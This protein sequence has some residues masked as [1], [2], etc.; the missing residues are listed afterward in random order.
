VRLTRDPRGR[1]KSNKNKM[2][3]LGNWQLKHA[4]EPLQHA[5][6]LRVLDA[7]NMGS[8]RG[9]DREG[10][11]HLRE[12]STNG[13]SQSMVILGRKRAARWRANI[14]YQA[15]AGASEHQMMQGLLTSAVSIASTKMRLSRC[16]K[17]EEQS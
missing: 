12:Q 2:S 17:E 16:C 13:P 11:Q 7:L 1:R 14:K 8:K 6:V 4:S 5:C 10:G 15:R 9:N 3:D